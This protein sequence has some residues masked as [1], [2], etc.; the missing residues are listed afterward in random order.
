MP[1][2]IASTRAA[3]DTPEIEN[4]RLLPANLASKAIVKFENRDLTLQQHT[5][6]LIPQVERALR[7]MPT[8]SDGAPSA[9]GTQAILMNLQIG[10]VSL[11]IDEGRFRNS[12]T[13]AD[14]QGKFVFLN[15]YLSEVVR[16]PNGLPLEFTSDEF[17]A[18]G[19]SAAQDHFQVSPDILELGGKRHSNIQ[20]YE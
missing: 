7:M 17:L 5:D 11:V 18:E 10:L 16:G 15:Q 2:A 20:F 1:S 12:G 8:T 19:R 13:S 14:G 4:V 9:D 6:A 3:Q